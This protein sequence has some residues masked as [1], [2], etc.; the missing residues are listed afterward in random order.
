[1]MDLPTYWYDIFTNKVADN[2][3]YY[4]FRIRK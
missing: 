3:S 2:P 4:Y 1:M